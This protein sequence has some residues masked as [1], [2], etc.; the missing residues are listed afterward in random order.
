MP[1]ALAKDV[2]VPF[3]FICILHL[4]N[5]HDLSLVP[6]A[7]PFGSSESSLGNFSIVGGDEHKLTLP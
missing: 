1:A 4:A 7:D 5:E 3:Y 2:S 6:E